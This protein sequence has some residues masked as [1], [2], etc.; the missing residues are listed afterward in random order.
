MH[1]AAAN[2]AISAVF[3]IR[4][5]LGLKPFRLQVT[6][7]TQFFSLMITRVGNTLRSGST[8]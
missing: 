4:G 1:G 5:R 8:A 7:L 2:F 3:G 6:A